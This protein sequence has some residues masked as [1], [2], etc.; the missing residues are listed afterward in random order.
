MKKT[1]VIL[2]LFAMPVTIYIIFATAAHN[3]ARLP[4]ITENVSDL[5]AFTP[6]NEEETLSFE[7][8]V[9]VLCFFGDNIKGMRGNAYNLLE[10]IYK[11]NH[12]YKDFK[13]LVIAK[14]GTQDQ[15]HD[16]L[17]QL[18]DFTGVNMIKWKFGFGTSE[19]IQDL[20]DSLKT[21]LEL[22]RHQTS[23]FV[24]IV[25]KDH[26][27]RGRKEKNKKEETETLYGYETRSVAAINNTLVDD[28]S[29]LLAEYRLKL[30][31]NERNIAKER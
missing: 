18:H 17:D 9:T 2:A 25:D 30:K 4:V 22:D 13:L 1:L 24:F 16:L 20:F 3:F 28:V 14:E 23:P 29:V 6:L 15:A 12:I 31:A 5:R 11:K 26:N 27:L 19:A 7:E 8:D 10:K 21:D